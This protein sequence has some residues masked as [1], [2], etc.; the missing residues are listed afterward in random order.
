VDDV[1][2]QLRILLAF[3]RRDL[4]SQAAYRVAFAIDV[5]SGMLALLS[6]YFLG[7]TVGR[8]AP[9][10]AA[11]G[12]D[13][14]A[15][16]VLGVATLGPMTTAL[17]TMSSQIR[18]SQNAGTLESVLVTPVGVGRVMLYGSAF[19]ILRA[20]ARSAVYVAIGVWAFG[21]PIARSGVP[22]ALLTLGL[23]VLAY[24]VLGCASAAFTLVF[25]RGDPVAFLVSTLSALAGGVVFPIHVLPWPLR[26]CGQLLPITPA[27]EAIRRSLL[28]GAGWREVW[29]SL[30]MLAAFIAV[31][32][33][34][35]V[36]AFARGLERA[37]NDGSLTHY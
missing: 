35:A 7:L 21:V 25:K 29:P 8:T 32:G 20:L 15:F 36:L 34:L 2:N 4:L 10:L 23:A 17:T 12:G 3:M 24:M 1:V 16:A 5:V 27:L 28:V 11:Y 26:L 13:Y 19:P 9:L 22:M 30:A 33:P 18:E 14:F 37:K 31:L 6:T